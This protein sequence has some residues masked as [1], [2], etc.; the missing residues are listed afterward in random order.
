MKLQRKAAL[1]ASPE[2]SRVMEGVR[3]GSQFDLVDGDAI[4][5]LP[6]RVRAAQEAWMMFLDI[7]PHGRFRRRRSHLRWWWHIQQTC[8]EVMGVLLTVG[9]SIRML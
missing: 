7:S 5:A 2:T 9:Q 6:H 1:H 3:S 8:E 4:R